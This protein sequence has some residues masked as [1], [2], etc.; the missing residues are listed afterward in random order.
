MRTSR[1]F[2]APSGASTSPT[3]PQ[4]GVESARVRP[5]RPVNEASG[6]GSRERSMPCWSAISQPF[7]RGVWRWLA[8][9]WPPGSRPV[10]GAP[11]PPLGV[12]SMP[13]RFS[14]RQPSLRC[15]ELASP[16]TDDSD[17]E[18][19][20]FMTFRQPA[21]EAADGLMVGSC[22]ASPTSSGPNFKGSRQGEYDLVC[23]GSSIP[24]N[25]RRGPVPQAGSWLLGAGHAA[26]TSRLVRNCDHPDGM[27]LPAR[28]AA[29]MPPGRRVS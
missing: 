26:S 17:L 25:P 10:T 20:A 5:R 2:G 21:A 12:P 14:L 28:P 22:S 15:E 18:G 7:R 16:R 1:T 29:T 11:P 27:M 6:I 23:I 9:R 4:S 8:G 24:S 19:V 13:N 3:S